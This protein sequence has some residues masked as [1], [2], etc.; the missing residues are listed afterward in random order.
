LKVET[1]GLEAVVQVV[2]GLGDRIEIPFQVRG[3]GCYE[4]AI[5]GAKLQSA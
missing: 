3:R 1:A 4:L 5:A 2:G